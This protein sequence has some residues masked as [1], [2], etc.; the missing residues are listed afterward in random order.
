MRNN[1]AIRGDFG[2]V[3]LKGWATKNSSP[4]YE[5]EDVLTT[6]YVKENN[7]GVYEHTA[8]EFK[9]NVTGDVTGNVNG[10]VTGNVDGIV[11]GTSPN[12][13]TGTTITA[14]TKFIGNVTGNVTGS[15]DGIVGGTSPNAVTGTTITA[16]KI[17][18]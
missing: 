3:I 5:P 7:S 6:S 10:N 4:G 14:N 15:L 13:V 18:W 1:W 11:G 9:G 12:A 2:K 17:Y 16:N 8:A